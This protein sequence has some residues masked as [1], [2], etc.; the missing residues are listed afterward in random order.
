[1]K[2]SDRNHS[3]QLKQQPSTAQ[4]ENIR[5]QIVIV[6]FFVVRR[7]GFKFWPTHKHTQSHQFFLSFAMPANLVE[8]ECDFG[9]A[10]FQNIKNNAKCDCDAVT[11][12]K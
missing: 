5:Y 11:R 6:L 4:V 3:S 10:Q 7:L 12:F 9:R 2:R 8:W 1:M